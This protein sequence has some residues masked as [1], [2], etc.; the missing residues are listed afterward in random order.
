MGSPQGGGSIMGI[1]YALGLGAYALV[2]ETMPENSASFS[3]Q[4]ERLNLL[5]IALKVD[6]LFQ[7]L[8]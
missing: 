4:D 1:E 7:Q 5:H 6:E 8:F 2:E 3:G